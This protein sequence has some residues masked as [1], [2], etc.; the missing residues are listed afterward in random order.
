[1]LGGMAGVHG[2]AKPILPTLFLL[3]V[4][5]VIPA[6]LAAHWYMR[7]RTLEA[8]LARTPS[9]L[10]GLIWGLMAFAIV[11]SQGTGNAFIYF[12]F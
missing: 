4:A 7:D 1:V 10:I 5:T 2:D 11:I 6:M 3:T 8:L 9:I 12:Q